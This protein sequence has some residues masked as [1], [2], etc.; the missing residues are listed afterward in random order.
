MID[1]H[2]RVT[3]VTR[4]ER[5]VLEARSEREIA[6]MGE[7]VLHRYEGQPWAV[8]FYVDGWDRRAVRRIALYLNDVTLE[9]ELAHEAGATSAPARGLNA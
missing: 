1:G 4:D 8:G 5:R 7:S 9:L 3:L 6:L 2:F